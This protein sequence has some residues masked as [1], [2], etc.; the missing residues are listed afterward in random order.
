MTFLHVRIFFNIKVHLHWLKIL[1]PVKLVKLISISSAATTN[2]K[3]RFTKNC[4][5]FMTIIRNKWNKWLIEYFCKRIFVLVCVH[6]CI[7]VWAF[8]CVCG[9]LCGGHL[10]VGIIVC[11]GICVYVWSFVCVCGHLCVCECICVL[12]VDRPFD[13]SC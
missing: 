3:K 8:V 5:V 11:V 6:L 2:Y 1:A 13:N 10:C 4:V 9:H 12:V 7:C